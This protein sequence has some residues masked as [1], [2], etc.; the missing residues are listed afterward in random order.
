MRD[1]V[2]ALERRDDDRSL[3]HE[4]DETLE[5]RALAMDLVESPRLAFCELQALQAPDGEPLFLEPGE[6]RAGLAS[7][8][9]IWFEDRESALDHPRSSKVLD[10]DRKP[11]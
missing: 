6:D 11:V 8:N 9:G 7:S 4:P 3:R 1:R 5:E 10:H 2:L